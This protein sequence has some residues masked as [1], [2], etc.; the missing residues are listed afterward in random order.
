MDVA[1]VTGVGSYWSTS[2]IGFVWSTP[3]RTNP[4]APR[5]VSAVAE[6]PVNVWPAPLAGAN[7]RNTLLRHAELNQPWLEPSCGVTFTPS[8][9]A[10][11]TSGTPDRRAVT[12]AMASLLALAAIDTSAGET[13]VALPAKAGVATTLLVIGISEPRLKSARRAGAAAQLAV[14]RCASAVGV[15]ASPDD[16][17]P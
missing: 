16:G 5:S 17:R 12:M 13:L 15:G 6:A 3:S 9:V 1:P 10:D 2:V 14:F 4:P 11:C 8:N 7:R